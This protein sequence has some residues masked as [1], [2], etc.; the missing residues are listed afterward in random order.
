M[1]ETDCLLANSH[2]DFGASPEDEP[3]LVGSDNGVVDEHCPL[4]WLEVLDRLVG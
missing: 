4:G 1:E 3:D 2:N